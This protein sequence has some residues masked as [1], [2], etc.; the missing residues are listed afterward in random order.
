MLHRK[1]WAR[2]NVR[3]LASDQNMSLKQ[4]AAACGLN[5]I[6]YKWMRRLASTGL[7]HVQKS[8]SNRLDKISAFISQKY[9]R[10]SSSGGLEHLQPVMARN[11]F[12]TDD[13]L[14]FLKRYQEPKREVPSLRK[15]V[16]S[17]GPLCSNAE[18]TSL[19]KQLMESG[20]FDY[21]KLMVS[22]LHRGYFG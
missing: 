14:L 10:R 8:G 9:P 5:S 1:N 3:D 11:A 21:L 2:E 18:A 7:V 17:R 6:G 4:L 12:L 20:R 13:L 19:F 15:V 16:E 22:D